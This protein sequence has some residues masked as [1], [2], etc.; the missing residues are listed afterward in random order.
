VSALAYLHGRGIA[1]RDIKPENILLDS[2]L[3]P[4][5][6]DLGL[7][8]TFHTQ[9]LMSTPCGTLFYV[10]PEIISGGEYDGREVDVWSLGVVLYVMLVA[11][12]PWPFDNRKEFQE[13]VF[14][15]EFTVP[16]YVDPEAE[17]LIR[18][19]LSLDPESRPSMT[20]ILRYPWLTPRE[21][22]ES[23]AILERAR[24]LTKS[25][26]TGVLPKITLPILQRDLSAKPVKL[27]N[28]VAE[29][30]SRLLKRAPPNVLT[31]K[32]RATTGA[33]LLSSLPVL[34]PMGPLIE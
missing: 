13:R 21:G 19:M 15:G 7:A 12:L 18:S 5:I 30:Q 9:N 20:E 32:R 27:R 10:A 8:H 22:E 2:D 31:R 25:D 1:H 6:A 33:P 26:T 11:A 17:D 16:G 29:G 3:S 34:S 24:T 14:Q 23:K 28:V 4:K